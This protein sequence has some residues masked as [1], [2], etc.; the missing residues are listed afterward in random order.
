MAIRRWSRGGTL[1]EL[2]AAA[3]DN[4]RHAAA[5]LAVVR[6]RLEHAESTL[7]AWQEPAGVLLPCEPD[8]DV[9]RLIRARLEAVVLELRTILTAAGL[10]P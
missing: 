9:R 5:L 2:A 10:R 1:G 3:A 4:E 6:A 8:P 7:E